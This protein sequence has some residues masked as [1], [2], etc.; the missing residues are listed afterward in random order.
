[1]SA[2][3]A[4]RAQL[5]FEG[6]IYL[7]KKL[8]KHSNAIVVSTINPRARVVH[9]LEL[10]HLALLK[11]LGLIPVARPRVLQAANPDENLSSGERALKDAERILLEN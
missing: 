8:D 10:Q 5:V 1:V 9:D 4:E 11:T 6:R 2:L 7:C 3:A